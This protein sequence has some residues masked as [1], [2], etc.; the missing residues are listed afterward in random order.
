MRGEGGV[1]CGANSPFFM[2][3]QAHRAGCAHSAGEQRS[4][5]G[6]STSGFRP[7]IVTKLAAPPKAI[8][9]I[10]FRAGSEYPNVLRGLGAAPQ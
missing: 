1:A 6:L 9:P 4:P 2:A 3:S 8:Q 10:I 5:Y 7:E